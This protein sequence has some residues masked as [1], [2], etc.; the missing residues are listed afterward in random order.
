MD[1]VIQRKSSSELH[2]E[3][4][5]AEYVELKEKCLET[6]EYKDIFKA[7]AA[8]QRMADALENAVQ[9]GKGGA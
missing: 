5:F 7:G 4:A 2:A 1:N 8:W 3:D 9:S 6:Q